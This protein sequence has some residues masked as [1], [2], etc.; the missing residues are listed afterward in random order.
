VKSQTFDLSNFTPLVG[1]NNAGKTN[2]LTAVKWLL[3]KSS[4]GEDCFNDP[5]LPIVVTGTI[6]GID[7]ALLNSLGTHE[8]KV[9]PYI[10]NAVLT[11]RRTQNSPGAPVKEI[12]LEV[13]KPGANDADDEWAPNPTGIDQAVGLIFPEAIH[14][15]AMEDAEEDTAKSKTTTTIGKL[16]GQVIGPI[17]ENYG[18]N[19]R[20]ALNS[21]S[22]MLEADGDSRAVELIQ[23]DKAVNEKIDDFFPGVAVRLHIPSPELKEVFN[24]GTIRVYEHEQGNGRD[25][26]SLGRGA[27]RSIQMAL[28]RHLAELQKKDGGLLTTTLLLID[29]P[30]LYLHPHAIEIVRNALK[31]L[32]KSGYQVIFTTH[33][34]IMITADDISHTILVRKDSERGTY[35]RN[36]VKD[37]VEKVVTDAAK[38]VETLFS[39]T[40]SANILFAEKVLLVEGLTERRLIPRIF[41][42][43][44][45][46]SLGASK[47]AIIDMHGTGSLTKCFRVLGLMDLPTIAI[48][49]FDY[50][51]RHARDGEVLVDGDEDVEECLACLDQIAPDHGIKLKDRLPITKESALSP[52]AA[53]ALLALEAAIKSNIDGLHAKLLSKNIWFWKKGTIENHLG[54]V[55]KNEQ[56]WANFVQQVTTNGLAATAADP[57]GIQACVNWISAG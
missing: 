15:G 42:H 37:C 8:S 27:Q 1:Y 48:V 50:V 47:I 5:A 57:E 28:I 36:S 21:V 7:E 52:A 29:E 35:R 54:I 53:F 40:N 41:E 46:K 55:E 18:A 26:S 19:V 30:E 4:L 56:T 3:K 23:F 2:V 51:F 44:Q 24:K 49:D 45:G 38:Q 9:R 11:I 43:L 34:P 22:C 33:S 6:D 13:K 14:I 10:D 17:E 32:S 16:L 20:E 25:V 39:L 31:T 12:S